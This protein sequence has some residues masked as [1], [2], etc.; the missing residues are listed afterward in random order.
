MPPSL[1]CSEMELLEGEVMMEASY[2]YCVSPLMSFFLNALLG[3]S[4]WLQLSHL[5]VA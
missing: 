2:S 1:F 5:D 3:G 4:V